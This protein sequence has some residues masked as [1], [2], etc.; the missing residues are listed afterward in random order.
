MTGENSLAGTWDGIPG[1]VL[2]GNSGTSEPI[3]SGLPPTF[4]SVELRDAPFKQGGTAEITVKPTPD[5]QLTG[6]LVDKPSNSFRM[7]METRSHLQ[8]IYAMLDPGP[9]LFS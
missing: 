5:V 9:Y 4:Q 2:F 3:A 8:G 7:K 1:D 6:M